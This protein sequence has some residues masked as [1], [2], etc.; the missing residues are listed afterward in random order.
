MLLYG[1]STMSVYCI[2][3]TQTPFAFL[4]SASNYNALYPIQ[5]LLLFWQIYSMCLLQSGGGRTIC[6]FVYAKVP[7]TRTSTCSLFNGICSVH[8][9]HS[10]DKDTISICAYTWVLEC[11][12]PR[13]APVAFWVHLQC[14]FT[15][16]KRPSHHL[17]FCIC[18]GIEVPHTRTSTYCILVDLQCEFTIQWRQGHHLCFSICVGTKA[19]YTRLAPIAFQWMCNVCYSIVATKAPFVLLHMHG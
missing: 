1:E 4:E 13:P 17:Q 19:P 14:A 6:V 8:L 18:L 15:A 16:Q 9:L 5:H 10:A 12:K 3:A 11:P 2:V 7:L